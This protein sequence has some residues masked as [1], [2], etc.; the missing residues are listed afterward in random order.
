VNIE[1]SERLW[2]DAKK[3]MPGGVNSPVRAFGAVGGTP[4]FIERGEG[5]YLYDVDGNRYLDYVLS[6]GPLVLGHAHPRVV[7]ALEH[8]VRRGTSY[9]APTPLEVELAQVIIDLIPSIELLRLVNSGTEAT[10][11]AI[12]LARAFTGRDKVVKFAG[13]YHGHADAFLVQAG[14][15]VST[16]GL[17]D[18]PGVTAAATSDTLT[19][20][21]NDL[22]ALEDLFASFPGQIAAVITEPLMANMGFIMPQPGF[23]AGVQELCRKSGTLF[24]LDEVIT[25]FRLAIEGAQG[26]WGLEPDLTCLGKVIGGGLPL[27]AYGGKRAIM[28]MVAPAGP[29]YQAGTLSGNPLATT[30]GL[31]T[32]KTLLEPGTFAAIEATARELAAG[33]GELADHAGIPIQIGQY[34]TIFGFY[35]L[36]EAGA[37]IADAASAKLH[38]DTKRYSEFFHLMLEQGI[39]FAPSQ[40]EVAFTSAAHG[41][42]E[43][44]TTLRAMEASFRRLAGT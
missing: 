31:A 43:V 23:L 41:E 32:L 30:A 39:Y 7:E 5:A 21:F 29:V 22:G 38:A 1:G 16:F 42:S 27:G 13:G 40:F 26:A 36:K 11:S 28:E 18:S 17:P 4:R 35:F 20:A 34:G 12:R 19:C 37:E 15:G 10:M 25:G 24:I 9:G 44:E 6:W 14:S 33:I 3:L 8:A 2:A